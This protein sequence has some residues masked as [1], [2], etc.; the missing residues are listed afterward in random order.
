MFHSPT[1]VSCLN[2]FAMMSESVE[3]CGCHFFIPEDL[4]PF[5][6]AEI[7]GDHDRGL[8]VEF[9]DEMKEELTTVI[10]EREVS[11]LVEHE[12]VKTKESGRDLSSLPGHLVLFKV[13][14][15]IHKVIESCTSP[16]SDRMGCDSDGQ[17][18]FTGARAPNKD[19]I[20]MILDKVAFVQRSDLSLIHEGLFEVE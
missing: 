4:W 17:M 15:Q 1:F 11:Q 16:V 7:G 10:R 18:S 13:I 6:K 14:G 3:H 9:R 20:G 5:T 2:D 8:L 19:Q 12:E